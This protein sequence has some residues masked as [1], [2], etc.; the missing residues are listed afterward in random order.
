MINY[1][2]LGLVI[3]L[4]CV[5]EYGSWNTP[6]A[7]GTVASLICFLMSMTRLYLRT[8]LWKFV[9]T[10]MKKLDEREA[11]V[12]YESLRRSYALFSVLCLVYIC[13]LTITIRFSINIVTSAGDASF[14]IIMANALIYLAHILPASIIAWTEKNGIDEETG[15]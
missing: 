13:I 10:P 7:A 8:G 6:L 2:S 9:H 3:V 14:G 5:G 4:F 11:M 1:V 15:S 12:I